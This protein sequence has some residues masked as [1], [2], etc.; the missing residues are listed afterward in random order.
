MLRYVAGKVSMKEYYSKSGSDYDEE[1]LK[2]SR[3]GLLSYQK[4]A[5]TRSPMKEENL[6]FWGNKRVFASIHSPTARKRGQGI[7]ASF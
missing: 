1:D 2:Q 4:F 7:V 3:T 5:N 6:C